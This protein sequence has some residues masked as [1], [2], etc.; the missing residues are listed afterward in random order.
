[1]NCDIY[2]EFIHKAVGRI[3][4]SYTVVGKHGFAGLCPRHVILK[5][6]NL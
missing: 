6:K 1:M 4:K 2:N 3:L 5:Q